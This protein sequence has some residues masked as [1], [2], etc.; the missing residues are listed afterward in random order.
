MPASARTLAPSPPCPSRQKGVV[1]LLGAKIVG[2]RAGRFNARDQSPNELRGHSSALSAVGTFLLA[3]GWLGFNLGSIRH[4]T[5][6]GAPR[7]AAHTA[8]CTSLSGSAGSLAALGVMRCRH[9]RPSHARTTPACL[10]P[11]PHCCL[12][13]D[14]DPDPGPNPNPDPDAVCER[15]VRVS[16]A[17][18]RGRMEPR[19]RVQRLVS[20]PRLHHRVRLRGRHLDVDR[21]RRAGRPPLRRS[22][23]CGGAGHNRP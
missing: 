6:P 23:A 7:V 15:G 20:R 14:A 1:A 5:L 22:L 13:P 11:S 12:N 8:V 9:P 19:A 18:A 3:V 17:Q 16:C 21:H 10:V 2:P 4:I